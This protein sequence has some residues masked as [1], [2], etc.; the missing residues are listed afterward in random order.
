MSR[1]PLHEVQALVCGGSLALRCSALAGVVGAVVAL[2]LPLCLRF[3]GA[4][5]ALTMCVAAIVCLVAGVFAFGLA[6]LF[7]A[8]ESA[9]LGVVAGMV[10]RMA[11]PLGLCMLAYAVSPAAARGGFVFYLMGF[12]ALTLVVETWI[13]I[14]RVTANHADVACMAATCATSGK[15]A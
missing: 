6:E 12:Y 4:A 9:A 2:A 10:V 13:A 15:E 14:C 5:A 7:R 3:G 1:R 11:I 8:P